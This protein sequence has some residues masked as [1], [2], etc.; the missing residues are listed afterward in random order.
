MCFI[1]CRASAEILLRF[2]N[3]GLQPAERSDGHGVEHK[4]ASKIVLMQSDM[5]AQRGSPVSREDQRPALREQED[6]ET[7]K[8]IID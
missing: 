3:S 7:H 2:A 1:Q 6:L 5:K 4:T 8:T